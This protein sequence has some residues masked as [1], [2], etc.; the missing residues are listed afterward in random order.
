MRWKSGILEYLL[1]LVFAL[2]ATALGFV[3]DMIVDKY[4]YWTPVRDLA[5]CS[6]CAGGLAGY[7]IAR[8]R[9][10]RVAVFI[11][12]AGLAW[13]LYTAYSLARMWSPAWTSTSRVGYVWSSLIGPGCGSQECIYTVATDLFLSFV[14]YSLGA[15]LALMKLPRASGAAGKA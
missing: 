11:W 7:L 12:I 13:L 4:Y 6:I 9:Q 8:F 1:Q 2:S 5:L 3:L 15:R 14:A 10:R